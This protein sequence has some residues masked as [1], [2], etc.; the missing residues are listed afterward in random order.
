MIGCLIDAYKAM[1]RGFKQ[2]A[3][4]T[5]ARQLQLRYRLQWL[6]CLSLVI[7]DGERAIGLNGYK[8]SSESRFENMA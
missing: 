7:E 4:V 8:G 5:I 2:A 3:Y 6:L 1:S